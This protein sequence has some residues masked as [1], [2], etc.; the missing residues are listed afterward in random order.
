MLPIIDRFLVA[1]PTVTR[2]ASSVGA[3]TIRMSDAPLERRA[4]I[5][6]ERTKPPKTINPAVNVTKSNPKS[7]SSTCADTL[8]V[9]R[10]TA[11]STPTSDGLLAA[12]AGLLFRRATRTR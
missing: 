9:A 7:S 6:D 2:S 8:L 10:R 11:I 1:K 5:S 12:T 4:R 3:R